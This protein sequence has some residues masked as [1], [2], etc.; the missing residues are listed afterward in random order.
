MKLKILLQGENSAYDLEDGKEKKFQ[1]VISSTFMIK[2]V[3]FGMNEKVTRGREKSCR[4][5]SF[6]SLAA[7][8][9]G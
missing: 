7:V 8:V 2:C 9:K 1:K 5:F 3:R 4:K 6:E